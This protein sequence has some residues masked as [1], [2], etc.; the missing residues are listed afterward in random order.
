MAR[1]GEDVD[2]LE[3]ALTGLAE[4]HGAQLRHRVE[5]K[6][7]ATHTHEPFGFADGISQPVIRGTYKGLKARR[8]DPPR[9][10]RRVH[11]RL[12]R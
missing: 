12:P 10:T 11:P 4:A 5:L 1:R 6:D 7:T 2:A 9:R 8:P 3:A